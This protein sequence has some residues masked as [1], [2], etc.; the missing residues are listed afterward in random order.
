[1][2]TVGDDTMSGM[3]TKKIPDKN[4]PSKSLPPPRTNFVT[5]KYILTLNLFALVFFINKNKV[6]KDCFY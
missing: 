3:R 2:S 4:P 1:M 5:D 6:S